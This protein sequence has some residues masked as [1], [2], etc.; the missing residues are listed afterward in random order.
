MNMKFILHNMV[1]TLRWDSIVRYTQ[2]NR[3]WLDTREWRGSKMMI[4]ADIF[5]D[6]P[7]F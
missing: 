4:F 3:A 7:L 1:E 6:H 5:L 2:T